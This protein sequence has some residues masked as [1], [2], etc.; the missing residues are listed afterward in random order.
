MVVG[1][2]NR[3]SFTDLRKRGWI[4]HVI[5][6]GG[7][8]LERGVADLYFSLGDLH[9]YV[10]WHSLREILVLAYWRVSPW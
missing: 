4:R 6:S 1:G 7:V 9:P 8:G 3:A 2:G 5:V 10:D